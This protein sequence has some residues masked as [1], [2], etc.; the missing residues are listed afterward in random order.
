ML[1]SQVKRYGLRAGDVV[2]G[3]VRPPKEN[4]KYFGLLRV[5]AVNG[6]PA[7]DALTRPRFE[8]LTPIF[9]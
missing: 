7:E 5:E 9:P 8:D 3:Q 6:Y 1:Q 4:E 2:I